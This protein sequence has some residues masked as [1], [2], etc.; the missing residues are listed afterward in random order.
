[1]VT[2]TEGKNARF[3]IDF[4]WEKDPHIRSF[5]LGLE[6]VFEGKYLETLYVPVQGQAFLLVGCGKEKET[7]LLEVKEI[8]AA[9]SARCREMK[10]KECSVDISV[11]TQ[12]LGKDAV[13]QSVLGLELGGY[14]YSFPRERRRRLPAVSSWKGS[15][16]LKGW[17]N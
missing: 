16:G 13:T 15:A 6:E 7:G 8:L 9:A 11:F 3:Y 10:V 1:M 17:R 4:A 12:L 5:R 2:V 14:S